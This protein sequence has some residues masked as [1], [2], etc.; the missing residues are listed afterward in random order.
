MGMGERLHRRVGRREI[1]AHD[2]P[3]GPVTVGAMTLVCVPI[4]VHDIDAALADASAARAAGADLV[5]F[6]L[7]EF[8]S[9]QDPLTEAQVLRLPAESPLPCIIT[10]RAAAEGGGY[11][12]PDADRVALFERLANAFGEG[13]SPP[14]YLDLEL[15]SWERS[16]NLRQKVRLAI[17]HPEQRRDLKTSLILSLHDFHGRPADLH[18]R[19]SRLAS[20]T[21]ASVVKVA[22]RA[23]SLRDAL[24][25]LDLP[26]LLRRPTIS[27]GMGEF[28]LL[29]RVLAP[30]FGGFLT[31]AS[32]RPASATAPGQPTIRDLLGLYRFRS[33]NPA[34]AI[35]GVIGWPVGHSRS[36]LLHNAG[37]DQARINAVYL[38]LPI[39]ADDDAEASY[40][41]FKATLLE[42]VAHGGLN[43]RGASVTLPHKESLARLAREQGWALDE[44]SASL[45]AANT[46]GVDRAASG[47]PG[48]IRVCNTD[49]P[50]LREE[51]SQLA[52]PLQGH[53]V[54][55]VG[56]GGV[57][58]A[59]VWAAQSLGARVVIVN[60]TAAHARALASAMGGDIRVL[61][62][63]PWRERPA[64]V[65]NATPVGMAGGPAPGS[66]PITLPDEFEGRRPAILDTVYNP[67]ATPLVSQAAARGWPAIGGE[68]MFIRQARAQF[69]VWTGAEPP[70]G[71]FESAL[72]SSDAAP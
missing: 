65:I 51:L 40:L 18:R 30:K 67:A 60:R 22:Y 21:D 29:T 41:S 71:L 31:F 34:T 58:R 9:G 47:E 68:G 45:G 33:I 27:L 72:A 8:F 26:A 62:A 38:P 11:D 5:E 48:A 63:P 43:F 23:R 10:C 59:A 42:L 25:L 24:E 35:Y 16:A 49:A 13:D 44:A 70:P 20:E 15:A 32:L 61:P 1:A 3:C 36:P 52:G 2:V 57:A 37:F 50:A 53:S 39:A 4:L 7:D 64:A 46:L 66:L 17:D 28:G 19:A 6:R 69:R 12:G 55:V 54:V 56:A 14:R